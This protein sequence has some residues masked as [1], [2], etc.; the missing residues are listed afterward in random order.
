M[1]TSTEANGWWNP[2]G[3]GDWRLRD[4]SPASAS[5]PV[6]AAAVA[7]AIGYEQRVF[8]DEH[9]V[10]TLRIVAGDPGTPRGY[11]DGMGDF[12]NLDAAQAA[13]AARGGKTAAA[14][15]QPAAGIRPADGLAVRSACRALKMRRALRIRSRDDRC[16]R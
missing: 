11:I 4:G 7:D 12:I 6:R 9:G 16:V 15:R 8:P 14:H 13:L 5:D 10:A 3:S 2:R 1:E